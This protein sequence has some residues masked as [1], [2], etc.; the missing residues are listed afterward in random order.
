MNRSRP[1]KLG[2]LLLRIRGLGDRRAE[3]EADLLELFT[4]RARHYGERYASRRHY[5]DVLS[6]WRPSGTRTVQPPHPPKSSNV[7]LDIGHDL[8]YAVRLFRRSPGVVAVTVL[9]L[10]LAIG[11]STA[12][13]SLLNA[14]AFRPTGIDDP[15]SAVRVMRAYRNGIGSS[16]RYGDY[17]LLRDGARSARLEASLRGGA[18]ISTTPG[19]DVAETASLLFVSGGYLSALSHRTFLGRPLT[20]AD[21]VQGAPPVAVVSYVSWSRRL[22]PATTIIGQ[23]IWL[24]GTPFTVVGVSPRG[25][26]G[27]ADTPPEVWVPLAN[28]HTVY[29]GPPLDRLSSTTVDIIGRVTKGYPN[30]QAEAELSAVAVSSA[31]GRQ[32]PEA[33]VESPAA[34][35]GERDQARAPA[36]DVLTGVRFDPIAGRRVGKN[37]SAAA[38]IVVIVMTAIGL[39]LLLACVNVA[40]LLLASAISRQREIGVRLALGASRGRIGRQL[41]TESLSLGLV[42]GASGLS[43]TALA[44]RTRSPSSLRC[45]SSSAPRRSQ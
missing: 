21:D 33:G 19:T 37:A 6:L 36:E 45:W 38:L 30:A 16:W 12:V 18:S 27:T 11:V 29:G 2:S 9:G 5:R 20:A 24:N 34:R 43:C 42:G 41:L 7:L 10:G 8:T 31:V 14:V 25:F 28:Y 22:G 3:V 26:S 15:A 44:R 32:E 40:N 39:V 4:T 23:P 13:F 1:P 35:Q 17:L